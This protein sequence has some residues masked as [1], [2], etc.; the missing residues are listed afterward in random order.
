MRISLKSKILFSI[1]ILI[2]FFGGVAA[3]TSFVYTRDNIL[4][5]QKNNLKQL[6]QEQAISLAS[7]M[8]N[9]SSLSTTLARQKEVIDFMLSPHSDSEGEILKLLESYNINEAFLSIYIIDPRGNT[10]VSTDQSF[11]GNN[12]FF[13]DYFEHAISGHTSAEVALGVTSKELGY[14]FSSPIFDY[15][16]NI[17]GAA[18]FKTSPVV[19]ENMLERFAS[20]NQS[21][22]MFVDRF[23]VIVYSNIKSRIFKT[24]TDLSDQ[25]KQYLKNERTYEGKNLAALGYE[26]IKAE[27]ASL[28]S[29]KILDLYDFYEKEEEVLSLSRV[30]NYPFFLIL[31]E[32]S[33]RYNSLAI[34]SAYIITFVVL[35]AAFIAMFF[36][37]FVVSFFLRPLRKLKEATEEVGK[38]N[39]SYRSDINTGDELEELSLSFNKMAEKLEKTINNIEAEIEKRT[40]KLAKINKVMIGREKKMTELKKQVK[41][42]K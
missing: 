38:G 23:G 29:T 21:R 33:D 8:G 39:L 18:V 19:I 2:L 37:L 41:N 26:K 12:Y 9:I 16:G 7:T 4:S 24:L 13:R 10:L 25:E 3:A 17:I 30:G 5:I 42:K 40:N 28:K 31:E 34:S 27:M 11:V 1:L 32:N 6:S 14:Y 35:L 22:I 15:S 36:M 20:V